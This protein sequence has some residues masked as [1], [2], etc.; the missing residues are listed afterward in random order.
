MGKKLPYCIVYNKMKHLRKANLER[1]MVQDLDRYHYLFDLKPRLDVQY[2]DK[3][4][5]K[6][7]QKLP[8]EMNAV[9]QEAASFDDLFLKTMDLVIKELNKPLKRWEPFEVKGINY[10]ASK[11]K[12][13]WYDVSD[14]RFDRV[15]KSRKAIL[16]DNHITEIDSN[17]EKQKIVLL[18]LPANFLEKFAGYEPLNKVL[19]YQRVEN[20]ITTN[21]AYN[22][23]YF[24]D[25]GNIYKAFIDLWK[26]KNEAVNKAKLKQLFKIRIWKREDC[27]IQ[28]IKQAYERKQQI[29]DVP[30]YKVIKEKPYD[31]QMNIKGVS[32]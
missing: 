1:Q 3:I 5:E 16:L 26:T 7:A 4:I 27:I 15:N 8:K 10:W 28:R 20:E 24:C 23:K 6:F 25:D 21:N 31:L 2:H 22:P 17:G 19:S 30:K 13:K 12:V 9:Y 32:S 11:L 29:A 14:N 18:A